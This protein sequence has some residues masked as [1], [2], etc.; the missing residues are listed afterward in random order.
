MYNSALS[1]TSIGAKIDDHITG[2]RGVYTFQ[3]HGEMYHNIGTLLPDN[4][5]EHPQFAQIYIY[6]TDNE[7]QNRMNIMPNFNPNIL[8]ELQQ[9]LNDINPYVK[10]FRQASDMLI[11]SWI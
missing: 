7:L 1:F 5:D 2:T 9:M 10:T 6:D 4:N 8:M 11:I 3:I